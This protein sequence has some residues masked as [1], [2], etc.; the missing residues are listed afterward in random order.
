MCVCVAN[1]QCTLAL[2]QV[3]IV[4][5]SRAERL[6]GRYGSGKIS[7]LK[8]L[9]VP[10][11]VLFVMPVL[12]VDTKLYPIPIKVAV[13]N[14]VS[15]GVANCGVSSCTYI[16]T[17]VGLPGTVTAGQVVVPA[18]RAKLLDGHGDAIA[19]R[20]VCLVYGS[21]E[22]VE[23]MT[24]NAI[25]SDILWTT[26]NWNFLCV[27]GAL[28][29]GQCSQLSPTVNGMGCSVTDTEGLVTISNVKMRSNAALSESLTLWRFVAVNAFPERQIS[30]LNTYSSWMATCRSTLMSVKV[31]NTVQRIEAVAG[32]GVVT[33]TVHGQRS[34]QVAANNSLEGSSTTMSILL[35]CHGN[36]GVVACNNI[37]A[38]L[39][40]VWNSR[41]HLAVK[42]SSQSFTAAADG[43]GTLQLAIDT[44]LS[45]IYLLDLN[46]H[47][48]RDQLFVRL[49]HEAASLKQISDRNALRGN[50][51]F[52][53][54]TWCQFDCNARNVSNIGRKHPQEIRALAADAHGLPVYGAQVWVEMVG[55]GTAGM[56]GQLSGSISDEQVNGTVMPNLAVSAAIPGSY[57]FNLR[58]FNP[59]PIPPTLDLP[60]VLTHKFYVK[61]SVVVTLEKHPPDRTAGGRTRELG[62]GGVAAVEGEMELTQVGVAV[63]RWKGHTSFMYEDAWVA[64]VINVQIAGVAVSKVET[65]SGVGD[66]E[67]VNV[68]VQGLH[69]GDYRPSERR[70]SRESGLLMESADV[71]VMGRVHPLSFGRYCIAVGGVGVSRSNTSRDDSNTLWLPEGKEGS[72]AVQSVAV[73][74]YSGLAT[75]SIPLMCS[76]AFA[77]SE[78]VYGLVVLGYYPRRIGQGEE[79]DVEVRATLA[80]GEPLEGVVVEAELA[81]VSCTSIVKPPI[82]N[83]VI[84]NNSKSPE[85]VPSAEELEACANS[86]TQLQFKGTSGVMD[87]LSR[88]SVVVSTTWTTRIM[89]Q[90]RT[91]HALKGSVAVTDTNGV[92]KVSI[93]LSRAREGRN[94]QNSAI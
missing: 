45:G 48:S 31:V 77:V 22:E 90:T 58:L 93:L 11:S 73:D 70:V 69:L 3:E 55:D 57:Q 21:A 59:A 13:T 43:T 34:V 35:K 40:R 14:L 80:S 53:S 84:T 56:V 18:P 17:E 9:V 54:Y 37:E 63:L 94:F 4:T 23:K 82:E 91:G 78:R 29:A 2:M 47:G 36:T 26:A 20:V 83:I 15:K 32:A 24:I 10:A 64:P 85:T 92:A 50:E 19:G 46:S 88:E 52:Q 6:T 68:S 8:V 76:R 25:S 71:S 89:M 28:P 30:C 87:V 65:T 67:H 44:R 1:S 39:Q 72:I 5:W 81:E 86:E 51:T 33:G 42:I 16:K 12:R 60:A 49:R 27:Q 66:S 61:D 7:H 62:G 41:S 75:T 38:T 74:T 79:F